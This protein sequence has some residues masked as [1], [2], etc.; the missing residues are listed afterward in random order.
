M[1]L[2][3]VSELVQSLSGEIEKALQSQGWNGRIGSSGNL[4]IL[5]FHL[6]QDAGNIKSY[7]VTTALEDVILDLIV[8]E[9]LSNARLDAIIPKLLK[10]SFHKNI[11]A[12]SHHDYN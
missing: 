7:S 12:C 6:L 10:L 9:C 3:K 11:S 8:Q 5:S 1:S 4:Q 2:E